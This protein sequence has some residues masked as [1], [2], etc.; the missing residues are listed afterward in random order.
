MDG[1]TIADR[2]LRSSN[3]LVSMLAVRLVFDITEN[4]NIETNKLFAREFMMRHLAGSMVSLIDRL[5]GEDADEQQALFSILNTFENVVEVM[6]N[7]VDDI[8]VKAGLLETLVNRL[9]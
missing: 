6:P 5:D 2:L 1:L 3:I 8:F 4:E 9:V 7:A